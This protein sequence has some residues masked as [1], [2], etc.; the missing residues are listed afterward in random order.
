MPACAAF[1]K[2]VLNPDSYIDVMAE[3][4]ELSSDAWAEFEAK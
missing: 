3:L 4:D 1:D 2:F